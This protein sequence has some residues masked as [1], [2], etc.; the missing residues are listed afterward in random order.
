M[1]SGV[2]PHRE[3]ECEGGASAYF[4]RA[5]CDRPHVGE[6]GDRVIMV[7]VVVEPWNRDRVGRAR[8]DQG[9]QPNEPGKAVRNV[10][11]GEI[12]GLSGA[13][14][15]GHGCLPTKAKRSDRWHNAAPSLGGVSMRQTAQARQSVANLEP[16]LSHDSPSFKNSPGT[17]L[18]T[19]VVTGVAVLGLFHSSP[20]RML[21]T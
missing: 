3:G 4:E 7:S 20:A 21:T 6:E 15:E 9:E 18:V 5:I 10:A 8:V 2:R 14:N 13:G 12:E 11:A 17:S 16:V 1:G 19:G